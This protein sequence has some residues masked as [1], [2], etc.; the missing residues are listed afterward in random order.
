MLV[1]TLPIALISIAL[2]AC[3]GKTT[4]DDEPPTE[5]TSEQSTTTA[6]EASGGESEPQTQPASGP[7]SAPSVERP[8]TAEVDARV[9]ASKTRLNESDGGRLVWKAIEAHGGLEAWLGS[10]PLYF[11]F[12]YRPLGGRSPN[13]TYQTVDP[14][15]SVA[16]HQ[17]APD[18]S[19]EFGWDGEKAWVH[20]PDGETPTNPRFWALTPYYFVGMPFVLADPGVEFETLPDAQFEG[21]T[22]NVVKVTFRTGTGDAPDD[23]YVLYLHPETHELDALRYIV[24]YPGFFPDG[25]H[26]PEKL[27]SYDGALKAGG[28]QFAESHRTFK[29]DPETGKIGEKVTE[30]TVTDLEFR[31]D[32]PADYF[33]PPEGARLIT[34]WK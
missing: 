1:R 25:G 27:M 28:L 29:F 10:G 19:V 32:T 17:V 24:T 23:F 21:Q 4:T 3:S 26:S 14:W 7:Q 2:C 16:R 18:K 12:N 15:N 13:D 34:G 20:P 11:R 33:A 31:P 6:T 9:K 8:S 22:Y 5:P 30:V